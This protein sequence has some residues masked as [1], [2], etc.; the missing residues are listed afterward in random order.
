MPYAVCPKTNRPFHVRFAEG[1]TDEQAVERFGQKDGIL[2]VPAPSEWPDMGDEG[3][4]LLDLVE[5]VHLLPPMSREFWGYSQSFNTSHVV[6]HGGRSGYRR[7]E[8][9]SS[10]RVLIPE[11]DDFNTTEFGSTRAIGGSGVKPSQSTT[12]LADFYLFIV[13]GGDAGTSDHEPTEI[14]LLTS[15]YVIFRYDDGIWEESN[16]EVGEWLEVSME[17]GSSPQE[18]LYLYVHLG[19]ETKAIQSSDAPSPVDMVEVASGDL[20]IFQVSDDKMFEMRKLKDK[21]DYGWS[22]VPE[23][24]YVNAHGTAFHTMS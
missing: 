19:F 1:F 3:K 2:K 24:E 14:D 18:G 9:G 21:D 16:G 4:S 7:D 23:I 5:S 6:T 8:E 20:R 15:Q 22:A 11:D 13:A 12:K 10:R 17:A